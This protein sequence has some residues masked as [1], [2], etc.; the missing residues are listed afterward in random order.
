[1]DDRKKRGRPRNATNK[2]IARA[3]QIIG[4]TVHTLSM[5]GFPLR[6][7]GNGI[8]EVVG[9]AAQ[10]TLRRVDHVGLP[11]GPD[12]IEQIYKTWRKAEKDLRNWQNWDGRS[13]PLP[14]LQEPTRYEVIYLRQLRPRR[15]WALPRYARS[16]LKSGGVWPY[17]TREQD[18][19]LEPILTPKGE[20]E[21]EVMPRLVRRK[22][23]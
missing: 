6:R 4:L 22:T 13:V 20:K 5:W 1:M 19:N 18:H 11:L 10:V 17:R 14:P 12:R 23:G 7:A 9:K 2:D 16:L 15:K 3:D 21:L 8:Y